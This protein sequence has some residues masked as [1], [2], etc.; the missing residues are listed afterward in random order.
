MCTLIIIVINTFCLDSNV[1]RKKAIQTTFVR[2]QR[3]VQ[4]IMTRSKLLIHNS[5]TNIYNNTAMTKTTATTARTVT[6]VLQQQ[7][8]HESNTAQ[9]QRQQQF[10]TFHNSYRAFMIATAATTS[11]TTFL[12][13]QFKFR[14][15]LSLGT[16]LLFI[17]EKRSYCKH[18]RCLNLIKQATFIK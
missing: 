13:Q 14:K 9:Q 17:V 5:N 18:C 7:Y 10:T 12:Q 2:A 4:E 16:L 11:A 15:K 1:K 6:T 3:S 8:R